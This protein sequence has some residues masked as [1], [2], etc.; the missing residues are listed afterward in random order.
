[1]RYHVMTVGH[2]NIIVAVFV[3]S[4][5]HWSQLFI[6]TLSVFRNVEEK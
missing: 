5:C 4:I 3:Y 6:Y 1:M 2:R